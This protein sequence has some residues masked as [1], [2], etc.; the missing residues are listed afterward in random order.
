MMKCPICLKQYQAV[1]FSLDVCQHHE[2]WIV[3]TCTICGK[4][5]FSVCAGFCYAHS[6]AAPHVSGSSPDPTWYLKR[7]GQEGQPIRGI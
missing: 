2:N 1:G 7:I 3:A 6:E 4:V 5:S